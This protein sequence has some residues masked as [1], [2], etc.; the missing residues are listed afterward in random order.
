MKKIA[1]SASGDSMNAQADPRFGRCPYYVL[2]TVRGE[3]IKDHEII[4][5][6]SANL[7][8]GAGIQ[9][10]QT[11]TNKGVD[12]VITGNIGPN[13]F[14]ALSSANLKVFTGASGTVSEVITDYFSEQLEEASSPTGPK[15]RGKRG[16]GRRR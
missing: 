3:E 2:V 1:I 9:A 8:R 11:V 7:S 13:A 10:A 4:K 5:N 12:I 15:G 16:G 6:E 14:N